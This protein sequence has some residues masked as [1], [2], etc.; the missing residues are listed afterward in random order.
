MGWR[1]WIVMVVL[2]V[3]LAAC[4]G[5]GKPDPTLRAFYDAVHTGNMSRIRG[6]AAPELFTPTVE[7]DFARLRAALPN[8]AP[9]ETKFVGRNQVSMMNSGQ[10]LNVTDLYVF[11]AHKAV[12][13]GRM[14]RPSDAQPWRVQGFHVQILAPADLAAN[15]FTFEGKG[16]GH[17]AFLAA[18]VAAPLLMIAALVKVIRRKGLRRKWLWGI[19]AFAGAITLQMNWTTGA[20]AVNWL[21]IQLIGAGV[22]SAAPEGLTPWIASFT[23][24]IGAILI[25]TGVWANPARAKGPRGEP[26]ADPGAFD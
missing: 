5:F 25:L 26:K 21:S 7:A 4:Q 19:L 2:G 9:L 24:P 20:V 11:K 1:R 13:V 18:T 10:T 17:Y 15:A 12:V 3:A 6:L 8:D 14:T 16:A 23:L 22:T